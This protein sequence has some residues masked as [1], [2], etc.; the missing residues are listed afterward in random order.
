MSCKKIKAK[1]IE[2]LTS[3]LPDDL[4]QSIEN[5]SK[6]CS[7]CQKELEG[8]KKTLHLLDQLPQI[9]LPSEEQ[10]KFLSEV[11]RKIKHQTVVKPVRYQWGWLLPRL[12]P[13]AVAASILIFFVT[14]RL[15]SSETKPSKSISYIFTSPALS[16]SGEFV[17]NYF[18]TNDDS[19]ALDNALTGLGSNVVNELEDY[20]IGQEEVGDLITILTDKEKTQLV[21]QIEEML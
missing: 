18:D 12:I 11:R 10:E 8:L 6:F 13:T 20:L 15:R 21:K 1:F 9:E 7:I 5:H 17:L 3:E 19:T 4:I 14:M 16:L 2:Y